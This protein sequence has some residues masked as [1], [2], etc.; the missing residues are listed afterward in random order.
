MGEERNRAV[1]KTVRVAG[2]IGVSRG[3]P[4]GTDEATRRRVV[5]SGGYWAVGVVHPG[6]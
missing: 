5:L 2:A 6:R 1:V 4:T 3:G